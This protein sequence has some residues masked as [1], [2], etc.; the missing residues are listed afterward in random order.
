M[1][2]AGVLLAATPSPSPTTTVVGSG[3]P[4]FLGFVFTFLLA[5]AA[6]LLFLSLTKHLRVV[7]RRAAQQAEQDEAEQHEATRPHPGVSDVGAAGADLEVDA[8]LEVGFD[9]VV[10]RDEDE[11]RA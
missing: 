4:G 9:D 8:D 6:V 10:P 5:G 2:A 11:G 3:S 1:S 7:Q